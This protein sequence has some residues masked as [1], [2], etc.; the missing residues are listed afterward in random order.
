MIH[1]FRS[2]EER[3][4]LAPRSWRPAAAAPLH[5]SLPPLPAHPSQI[6]PAQI[7]G[8]QKRPGVL[9]QHRQHFPVSSHQLPELP[10][11]PDRG[12]RCPMDSHFPQRKGAADS[13]SHPKRPSGMR[14][15]S[16]PDDEGS[17]D[18]S[19]FRFRFGQLST[20]HGRWYL[21]RPGRRRCCP[22]RTKTKTIL[23]RLSKTGP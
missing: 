1:P 14:H 23:Q 18:T 7:H 10:A 6:L 11:G 21:P 12:P 20:L 2:T 5:L 16:S 13:H 19:Q 22:T 4:S 17:F 9:L 3:V 15:L 8:P